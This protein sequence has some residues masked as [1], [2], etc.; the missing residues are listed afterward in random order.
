[1]SNGNKF[2]MDTR[3]FIHIVVPIA[4]AVIGLPITI[5]WLMDAGNDLRRIAIGLAPFL[6]CG[7]TGYLIFWIISR[8]CPSDQEGPN[9]K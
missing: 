2:F 6:F 1:M 8:L 5:I 9:A 3:W 7:T 4:S